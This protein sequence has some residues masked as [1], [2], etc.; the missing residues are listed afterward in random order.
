MNTQSV[1]NIINSDVANVN[2]G[3]SNILYDSSRRAQKVSPIHYVL[4]AIEILLLAISLCVLFIVLPRCE[5]LSFDYI[6]VMV[7]TLSIIV[8]V[9]IGWNVYSIID[10]KKQSDMYSLKISEL[11]KITNYVNSNNIDN[12]MITENSIFYIYH[13]LILNK[14]PNGLVY[15]FLWHGIST[16]QHASQNCRFEICDN[17]VTMMNEIFVDTS[18]IEMTSISKQR[19]IELFT[20]IPNR[21]NIKNV[22][23]II[24]KLALI[25]TN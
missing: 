20:S 23:S 3:D 17:L 15:N 12:Q 4:L 9:L 18:K 14:S 24:E 19:L 6:G 11:A 21:N 10:L 16:I 22:N 25:K 13:Y 5:H 8:M 7:T 2:V 1:G